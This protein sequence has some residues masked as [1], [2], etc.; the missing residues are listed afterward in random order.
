[1]HRLHFCIVRSSSVYS[2]SLLLPGKTC[3][4][5]NSDFRILYTSHHSPYRRWKNT[6]LRWAYA[7]TLASFIKEQREITGEEVPSWLGDTVSTYE[8]VSVGISK[9]DKRHGWQWT[10]MPLMTCILPQEESRRPLQRISHGGTCSHYALENLLHFLDGFVVVWFRMFN[11]K[12][13]FVTWL[14][15]I[16]FWLSITRL[17]HFVRI[18]IDFTC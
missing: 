15:C 3:L 10:R 12:K 18:L 16:W 17:S 13:V 8:K 4:S 11:T 5:Y 14:Y 1:M 7:N 6:G 9:C 2:S